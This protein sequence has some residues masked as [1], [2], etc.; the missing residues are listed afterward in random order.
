MSRPITTPW[1]LFGWNL[2]RVMTTAV[3]LDCGY[4]VAMV[5]IGGEF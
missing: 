1:L 5:P 3:L 4:R 2:T